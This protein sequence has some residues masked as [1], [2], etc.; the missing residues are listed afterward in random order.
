MYVEVRQE[1]LNPASLA[2]VA[3]ISA[4][5]LPWA[6][7][8]CLSARKKWLSPESPAAASRQPVVSAT[9][10][11]PDHNTAESRELLLARNKQ[12]FE[13]AIHGFV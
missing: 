5:L 13:R 10:V 7:G 11:R 4:Y 6:F 1:D 8:P 12:P 9:A 2:V 3:V